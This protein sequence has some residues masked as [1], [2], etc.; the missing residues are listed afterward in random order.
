MK[1]TGVSAVV[2]MAVLFMFSACTNNTG[3]SGKVRSIGKTSEILVVVENEQQW[4]EGKMFHWWNVYN[5]KRE[6]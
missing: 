2:F 1:K 4:E 6:M 3:K 5:L